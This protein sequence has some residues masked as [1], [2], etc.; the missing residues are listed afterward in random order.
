M[1]V[2]LAAAQVWAGFCLFGIGFAMHRTGPAFKRHPAGAPIVLLGLAIMLLHSEP[3]SPES[4]LVQ[5]ATDAVPWIV[6][7]A[8]GINLVLSG[9]PIYSNRKPLILLVGLAFILAAWYFML[10]ILPELTL[11]EILSW[12]ASILGALLAIAVFAQ[13]VRYTE[14]KT[15]AAPESTPLS[16]KERKYVQSVLKRHLEASDEP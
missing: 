4:L 15:P 11:T 5:A 16:E 2:S 13:S 6:S 3:P 7:A 10:G 14:S 8:I 12:L 9:A 1:V